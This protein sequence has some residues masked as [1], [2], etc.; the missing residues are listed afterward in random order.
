MDDYMI[1]V[2]KFYNIKFNNNMED[3]SNSW[4]LVFKYKLL[5]F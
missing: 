5:I 2:V 3:A 1:V 4:Y